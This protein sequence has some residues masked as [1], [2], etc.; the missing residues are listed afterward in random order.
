M[1][2]SDEVGA[3][4]S[5][6]PFNPQVSLKTINVGEQLHE[7]LR[8]IDGSK[9]LL[10]LLG[11]EPERSEENLLHSVEKLLTSENYLNGP[12][13]KQFLVQ[14]FTKNESDVALGSAIFKKFGIDDDS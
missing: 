10:W 2:L 3:V 11:S 7:S 4:V 9:E 1:S 14:F 12:S 13:K 5:E 6:N 8:Q